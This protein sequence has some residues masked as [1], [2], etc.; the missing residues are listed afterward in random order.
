MWN[1]LKS[2]RANDERRLSLG[3]SRSCRPM[4]RSSNGHR[5]LLPSCT[6][7]IRCVHVTFRFP[8]SSGSPRTRGALERLELCEAKVSR[9]VLRGVRR[10]RK[11]KWSRQTLRMS[12][13]LAATGRCSVAQRARDTGQRTVL[14]GRRWRVNRL[15]LAGPA[16]AACIRRALGHSGRFTRRLLWALPKGGNCASEHAD[17]KEPE[18]HQGGRLSDVLLQQRR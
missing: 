1:R 10:R 8:S 12:L 15:R 14:T 2:G 7:G 11:M 4:E 3:A 5:S 9:T 6:R 18:V 13:A 17:G 16:Q